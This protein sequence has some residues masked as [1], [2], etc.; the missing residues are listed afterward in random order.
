MNRK[1]SYKTFSATML[2]DRDI[3]IRIGRANYNV[4]TCFMFA[5]IGDFTDN[6]GSYRA[7]GAVSTVAG[8]QDNYRK[9]SSNGKS[10]TAGSRSTPVAVINTQI[11][12]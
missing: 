2:R 5:I 8:C 3:C 11:E 10:A 9:P 12:I 7:S 1:T 6:S 4:L